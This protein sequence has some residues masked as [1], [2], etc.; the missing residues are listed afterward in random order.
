MHSQNDFAFVRRVLYLSRNISLKAHWRV[1][2]V[3]ARSVKEPFQS[4]VYQTRKMPYR[5]QS[6]VEE[7]CLQLGDFFQEMLVQLLNTL[8]NAAIVLVAILSAGG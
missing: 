5:T 6:E 7:E 8:R 3:L 1:S 4:L 2:T